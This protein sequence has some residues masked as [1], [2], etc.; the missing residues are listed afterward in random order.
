MSKYIKCNSCDGR[1]VVRSGKYGYFAGC[2]EYPRCKSTLKIYELAHAYIMK[3]GLN[4]YGW[5]KSCWKCKKDTMVYSYFLYYEMEEIDNIFSSVH[6]IGLGDIPCID[7]IISSKYP[8]IIMSYSNTLKNSYIANTCQHCKA[9]QGRNYVVS[10][11]HEIINE[12][13]HEHTMEKYL[14][15][16]IKVEDVNLM[17][18]LKK[19][20]D[21]S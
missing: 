16:T 7:N 10:D 3:Y 14:V 4:L 18:D 20:V 17:M 19:C 15:E 1:Y 9:L 13:Y 2:S 5:K 21:L 12:L 8:S 11:P 6:G